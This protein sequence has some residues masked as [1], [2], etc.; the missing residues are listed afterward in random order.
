MLGTAANTYSG[1]PIDRSRQGILH[2]LDACPQQHIGT[3]DTRIG[4][5]PRT[6]DQQIWPGAILNPNG[7]PMPIPQDPFACATPG[8]NPIRRYSVGTPTVG[9]LFDR[10]SPVFLSPTAGPSRTHKSI[11]TSDE[12]RERPRKGRCA[13]PRRI[14][15]IHNREDQES[16]RF[17]LPSVH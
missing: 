16:F 2:I 7:N 14:T 1:A 8:S 6:C 13:Y 17:N 15:R 10:E 11:Q 5:R 12:W 3:Y 9:E 4:R